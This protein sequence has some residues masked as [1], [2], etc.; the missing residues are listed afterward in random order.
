MTEEKASNS[1]STSRRRFLTITAG[2]IVGTSA[3]A[4]G[5][6]TTTESA[7]PEP[8][9]S[10][11]FGGEVQAWQGRAPEAIADTENPTL[12][13]EAGRVYE[14]TW[15]NLDGQ[16]H[17]WAFRDGDGND[18]AVIYPNVESGTAGEGTTTEAATATTA[19]ETTTGEMTTVEPPEDAIEQTEQISEEGATQTFHFV[20]TEEIADYY[21]PVHPNTMVGEVTVQ[22][23]DGTTTSE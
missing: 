2:T 16:P 17:N 15:E 19:A 21:C 11:R 20:A 8:V 12:E 6:E 3:L 1:S 23:G 5:Q 4:A 14:V 7:A 13:L 18:L 9:E 22:S 10:Y